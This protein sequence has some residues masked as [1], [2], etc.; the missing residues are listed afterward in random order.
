MTDAEKILNDVVAGI[1]K[2][3]ESPYA[4]L[5]HFSRAIVILRKQCPQWKPWCDEARDVM[6]DAEELMMVEHDARHDFDPGSPVTCNPAEDAFY[7]KAE[8]AR[9]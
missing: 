6:S 3:E 4:S 1:L 7:A 5:S 9:S 2:H 8:T